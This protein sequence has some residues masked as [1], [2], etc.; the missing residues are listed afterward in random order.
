MAR[1]DIVVF[2]N[3]GTEIFGQIRG[4]SVTDLDAC[5]VDYVANLPKSDKPRKFT[6]YYDAQDASDIQWQP[7]DEGNHIVL[8]PVESANI[9]DLPIYEPMELAQV[10]ETLR[11]QIL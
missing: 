10:P 7:Y 3:G 2:P 9:E 5:I 1:I 11:E 4:A 6:G 8:V